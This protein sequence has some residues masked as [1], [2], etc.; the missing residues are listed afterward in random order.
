MIIFL[1][2]LAFLGELGGIISMLSEKEG[3]TV[4]GI[5]LIIICTIVIALLSYYLGL[6]P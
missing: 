1:L 5:F 6:K 3:G 2:I 4:R